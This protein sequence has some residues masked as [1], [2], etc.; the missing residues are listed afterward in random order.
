MANEKDYIPEGS[1]PDGTF[2]EGDDLK[3]SSKDTLGSYL[4]SITS[5]SS[6]GNKFPVEDISRIETSLEGSAGAPADFTTGGQDGNEGFTNTFPTGPGSSEAAVSD[7]NTLSNSGKIETLSDVINKN[8]Q[9]DGHT[10]F[11]DIVS[12]R[13]A[14]EPGVGNTSGV[15]SQADP[16]SASELQQKISS[17]LKTGNR[18]DPTPGSSPYIEDGAFTEPGIPIEQNSF[19][20]YDDDA[21]RTS[22]RDLHNIANSMLLRQSGHAYGNR[23]PDDDSG[24]PT[25]GVQKG[26]EKVGVSRMRAKNAF[27][28]PEKLG[29]RDAE[30]RYDDL[31]GLPLLDKDSFG[32]LSTYKEPFGTAPMSNLNTALQST[33]EYLIGATVFTAILTLIEVLELES[34]AHDPKSPH[35]LTK[36]AWHKEGTVLR[37]LRQLGIPRLGEPAWL[38]FIYGL[39]AFMKL[40]PSAL[41]DPHDSPSPAGASGWTAVGLWFTRVLADADDIFF[42]LLYGSGYYANTM[43]VV[44]RDLE[45]MLDDV[46]SVGDE[47][48]ALV[49]FNLLTSLNSYPAWNFFIAILRMGDVWL[50]SYKRYARFPMMKTSGQTRQKLSRDPGGAKGMAWR[51]R[52]APALVLLNEKYVNA[53]AQFGYDPSFM[54]TLHNSIGDSYSRSSDSPYVGNNKRGTQSRGLYGSKPSAQKRQSAEAVAEIENELD[55]EYCPFYLHDLRT[56]EVL[57]FHAFLG[58]LKDSYSVS[59]AE[60]GGYGRIDKVKIYQDT[61]RSIS[62]SWTMVA[63]S[64]DDFDSMW[65]SLNKLISMIYPQFSM[66][67]PVRAGSKKFIMPFSQ[68]PTASPVIR[69]RVGDV[70]RSNY[71]RFNLARIFG[72]SEVMPAPE[73]G[74]TNDSSTSGD[75]FDQIAGAAFDISATAAQDSNNQAAAA[76]DTEAATNIAKEI[77]VRF[78]KEPA[79]TSDGAY[80]YIPGD[81]K[82]GV[83]TLKA[84]SAGYTTY[85]TNSGKV[86]GFAASIGAVVNRQPTNKPAP[87]ATHVETTPFRSRPTA[88][89]T[90]VIYERV[91]VGAN[92]GN[93]M[94]QSSDDTHEKPHAEYYVQYKDQ[95]DDADPYRK[96]S[97]KGHYHTYVVTSADLTPIPPAIEKTAPDNA[98]VTLDSQIE[99]TTKF[100]DPAN[101][102]I[103]RSF[104][105]AGGRGLAGVITSFDMDWGDAQWDMSGIG[106]RAPTLLNVSISFSPIHDIVPG[107]DNNGMMRAINY[108]VGNIA[109]PLGTDFYDQGGIRN[110]SVGSTSRTPGSSSPADASTVNY[111][112]FAKSDDPGG[113]EG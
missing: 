55:A 60:S 30:L 9:S 29:L 75:T 105:A 38:C 90:V 80:G 59:Y 82:W 35:A 12:S 50:S 95:D 99:A 81:K 74:A 34:G 21:V 52:S 70:I 69:L 84:N 17:M 101:N 49:L 15:S 48:G 76:K 63:T 7:F 88:S 18:F 10:I 65:W 53:A 13:E 72:L 107:L 56:N 109:G 94:D 27:K 58:D 100:F 8:A 23:N 11:R 93:A 61:T 43:R 28:A 108:P 3:E 86:A 41:P 26:G 77:E 31:S 91:V 83:A 6:T 22:L 16:A 47:G 45:N 20:V 51:H 98:T 14:G 96:A 66:G 2:K 19:G 113:G 1:G 44:R 4:S 73:G 62:L 68:I 24:L 111:R 57:G 85:D 106:R 36:G 104:E 33:G 54:Q 37:M 42:N 64:P 40:P 112:N 25:T 32:A 97:T 67:K 5:N 92:E 46:I 79:S 78:S 103:V 89:G 39:A 87:G 110:D 71:S 102:A